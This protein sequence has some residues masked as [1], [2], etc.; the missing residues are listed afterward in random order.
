MKFAELVGMNS[1]LAMEPVDVLTDDHLKVISVLEFYHRHVGQVRNGLGD[2][3]VEVALLSCRKG[4][5]FRLIFF[6][7][8]L[9]VRC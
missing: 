1:T 8:F 6:L 3:S 5:A 2:G 7:V 9:L 4:Y